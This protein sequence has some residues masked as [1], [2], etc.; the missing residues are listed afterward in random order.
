LVLCTIDGPRARGRQSLDVSIDGISSNGYQL[1]A[2]EAKKNPNIDSRQ[3]WSQ[4]DLARFRS[5]I[6]SQKLWAQS[7]DAKS[8]RSALIGPRLHPQPGTPAKYAE[9]PAAE[10]IL[11]ATSKVRYVQQ[12][13]PSAGS[14]AKHT[15][16]IAS[17]SSNGLRHRASWRRPPQTTRSADLWIKRNLDGI[18]Y[19]VKD[20]SQSICRCIKAKQYP[21]LRG[22]A[23]AFDLLCL[24]IVC[25]MARRP[26]RFF[27]RHH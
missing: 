3:S 5:L 13:R 24:P 18:D 4:C 7:R 27:V 19:R 23:V 9:L 2:M 25:D 20:D 16:A 6:P 17:V 8:T 26:L 1:T 11:V 14:R 22:D 12:G 15:T 21:E 10:V